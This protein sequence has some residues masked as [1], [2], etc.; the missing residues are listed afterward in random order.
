MKPQRQLTP[1]LTSPF[2]TS[3]RRAA[4]PETHTVNR[5]KLK[6]ELESKLFPNTDPRESHGARRPTTLWLSL[7]LFLGSLTIARATKPDFHSKFLAVGLSRT[8]PAF[9]FFTVNSLGQGKLASNPVLAETNSAALP[10]LE[11]DAWCFRP[12]PPNSR[13]SSTSL[14]WSPSTRGW[15]ASKRTLVMTACAAIS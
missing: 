13:R 8:R 2:T 11:L 10:G 9:S 6:L 5:L 1:P 15:R 7:I 3:G 14:R 12:R 4:L